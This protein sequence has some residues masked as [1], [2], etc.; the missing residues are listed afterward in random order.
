MQVT[1]ELMLSVRPQ[2]STRY[3][4][5]RSFAMRGRVDNPF[6]AVLAYWSIFL[7]LRLRNELQ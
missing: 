4:E 6:A 3:F 7:P 2:P 1:T 5:T